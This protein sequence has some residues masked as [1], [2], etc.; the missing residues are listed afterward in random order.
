MLRLFLWIA[1]FHMCVQAQAQT[2]WRFAALPCQNQWLRLDSLPI[3][4]GSLSIRSGD[5]RLLPVTAILTV[6]GTGLVRCETTCLPGDSLYYAWRAI[7]APLTQKFQLLDE[8]VIQPLPEGEGFRLPVDVPAAATKENAFA[9]GPRISGVMFRGLS[10]GNN[11]NVVPNSGL[12]LQISGNLAPGIGIEAAITE[13]EVPFQPEGS[14]SNLQDF[15]RI[16]MTL[17]SAG[18]KITLGDFPLNSSPGYFLKYQKKARGVYLE[19]LNADSAVSV[20]LAAAMSRGRFSRN[21]IQGL[22]RIQGPYRL[23]GAAG[24]T[25]VV[26]VSGSEVVYLD[27]KKLQRGVDQDY[28]IDYNLGEL[29]FNPKN[30]ITAFSRIVVEFQYSDRN[31]TRALNTG[32]V[33]W[34]QSQYRVQASA[35]SESDLKNQ[36]LFQNLDLYDSSRNKDARSILAEAG[37]QAEKAV[38]S[39][40][41]PLPDF[42][43]SGVNYIFKDSL[44][45]RFLEYTAVPVAGSSYYR[46]SFSFVGN[47]KGNYIAIPGGS[48]GRIYRWVVPV[49]GVPAGSY[50]PLI[51]LALPTRN[52]MIQVSGSSNWLPAGRMARWR[53]ELSLAASNADKNTFSRYG[54]SL[55]QGRAGIILLEGEQRLKHRK[56]DSSWLLGMRLKHE[57]TGATFQAVERFRDVEFERF[58]NRGLQNPEYRKPASRELLWHG[59]ASLK[60]TRGFSLEQRLDAYQY[61][62]FRGTHRQTA[63]QWTPG[64]WLFSATDAG[65]NG[66]YTNVRNQFRR[67]SAQVGYRHSGLSQGL[68]WEWEQNA[69]RNTDDSLLP[70]RSYRF[71]QSAYYLDWVTKRGWTYGGRLGNRLDYIIDRQQFKKASSGWNGSLNMR[72]Q[73]E[74]GAYWN[75]QLHRRSLNRFDSSLLLP[76]GPD[77]SQ[78]ML[79]SEWL[80]E[81][82]W[83]RT[84]GFIQSA[85]G[86][87]QRRQYVYVEVP[88]GQGNFSWVDYNENKIQEQNEFEP[89]V[90]RDQARFIRLLLPLPDFVASRNNDYTLNAELTAPEH[91]RMLRRLSSSHSFVFSGKNNNSQLVAS[92]LPEALFRE[93]ANGSYLSGRAMHRHSL[94]YNKYEGRLSLEYTFQKQEQ[95]ALL[96]NG[97]ERRKNSR[98]ISTLRLSG[99]GPWLWNQYLE[100]SETGARSDFF[101]ANNYAF[102][103]FSIE[104]KITY[105]GQRNFRISLFGKY[106][107]F[108]FTDNSL[109][110]GS[111]WDAGSECQLGVFGSSNMEASLSYSR[112]EF[113]GP[114]GGPAAFDVLRGLQPG[115]NLRWNMALRMKTGDHVQIDFGYEG[116]K[117]AAL[118]TI[119]NGRVEA[120]YLF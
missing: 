71:Q 93:S 107:P 115:N 40:I 10:A 2:T 76:S 12:N 20:S 41:R 96:G 79:R 85:S 103:Q 54:D 21:Q 16:Y 11:Q 61:E 75:L 80:T 53:S 94:F 116:R 48:N 46:A 66:L 49:G 65:L 27:G 28:V 17:K 97:N 111:Q 90:F 104:E 7:T 1:L 101:E 5:G 89:A 113:L 95:N 51:S 30:I 50:E 106:L 60:G 34:Q 67:N 91:W 86:R 70:Q 32:N 102:R 84:N 114:L 64:K 31:Y 45:I 68:L 13:Q 18:Q 81:N 109:R 37:N 35:Y 72:Y 108:Q 6:P 98:H 59:L 92:L 42:D 26:V 44:G 112:I 19:H 99:S 3:V 100:L 83:L 14:S 63:L 52:S 9:G 8:R 74:Q 23:S 22:E 25:P 87:E 110:S 69:A 43:V 58:W 36:P 38:I 39:G 78:W 88:A 29:H 55:N 119:H 73:S 120:R 33:V 82:S 62:G 118:N 4:S 105:N 47:G 24:E 56:K 77:G 117:I 15:D 57:R